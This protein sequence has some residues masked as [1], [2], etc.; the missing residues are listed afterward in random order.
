MD[1]QGLSFT[2]VMLVDD[3]AMTNM[4]NQLLL[5]NFFPSDALTVHDNPDSA[6]QWLESARRKGEK[7]PDLIL[8]DI[9]M[10]GMSGWE[11]VAEIR[12]RKLPLKVCM[13]SSSI[14]PTD[15]DRVSS[16]EEVL[17]YISKPLKTAHIPRLLQLVK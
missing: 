2:T 14:D 8:L 3:D 16:F 4:M 12:R 10:P 6:L 7:L 9:D 17:D 13:L 5:R 11:L 15:Q 1:E